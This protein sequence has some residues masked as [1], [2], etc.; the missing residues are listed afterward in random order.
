MQV[1]TLQILA[2]VRLRILATPFSA[3]SPN[4]TNQLPLLYAG[5]PVPA[6]LSIQTSFHW[7]AK[8]EQDAGRRS[9]RMRFDI[10]EMVQDW[11]ICGQKRGDFEAEVGLH[12][13]G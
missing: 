11:L 3:D 10:E 5:Q 1:V 7:D 4:S 12:P 9:Y 2:A 13:C 6:L 8:Q